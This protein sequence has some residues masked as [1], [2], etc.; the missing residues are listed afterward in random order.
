MGFWSA[1]RCGEWSEGGELFAWGPREKP[2]FVSSPKGGKL[3]FV[4]FGGWGVGGG[5]VGWRSILEHYEEVKCEG[6]CE[7]EGDYWLE[8][9]PKNPMS[10]SST[11][12]SV[13]FTPRIKALLITGPNPIWKCLIKIGLKSCPKLSKNVTFIGEIQNNYFHQ[14]LRSYFLRVHFRTPVREKNQKK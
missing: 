9:L 8:V 10:L 3:D 2:R 13:L 5:G 4:Y 12:Q 11:K 7:S 6:R 1:T 14:F